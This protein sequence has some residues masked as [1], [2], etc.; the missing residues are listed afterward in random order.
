MQ[1]CTILYFSYFIVVMPLYAYFEWWAA[2]RI[3]AVGVVFAMFLIITAIGGSNVPYAVISREE[4][5]ITDPSI[6]K[7]KMKEL[8]G[9]FEVVLSTPEKVTLRAIS[10]NKY[11]FSRLLASNWWPV[12]AIIG[13]ICVTFIIT[14]FFAVDFNTLII[15][16]SPN[17]EVLGILILF[18]NQHALAKRALLVGHSSMRGSLRIRLLPTEITPRRYM[19]GAR[20]PGRPKHYPT[21]PSPKLPTEEKKTAVIE[22]R[23]PLPSKHN[24]SVAVDPESPHTIDAYVRV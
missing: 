3:N 16:N 1:L 11:V 22:D 19:F 17:A 2:Q 12:L 15:T 14:V 18:S 9:Y 10:Q 5:I 23:P 4:E 20:R 13:C 21:G 6:V 7:K 8:G 24:I